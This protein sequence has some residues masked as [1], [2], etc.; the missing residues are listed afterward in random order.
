M[1]FDPSTVGA[2]PDDTQAPS[3]SAP[4]PAAPAFDPTALGAI[5]DAP[6]PQA[7][8]ATPAAPPT[9]QA[10]PFD[11]ASAGAVPD[12]D[13][14]S[15]GATLDD[16]NRDAF[17]DQA[18]QN[19]QTPI[20]QKVLNTAKGIGE[21]LWSFATDT[22]PG[23]IKGA[24]GLA[25]AP[26]MSVGQ[27]ALAAG[28]TVLSNLATLPYL[29][30]NAMQGVE[31]I[32]N[33]NFGSGV[34]AEDYGKQWDDLQSQNFT[35][36]A[37]LNQ[38]L[39]AMFGQASPENALPATAEKF[40]EQLSPLL[41]VTNAIPFAGGA[42]AKLGR[43]G[44]VA[45]GDDLAR[46]TTADLLKDGELPSASIPRRI[47][48]GMLQK[49]AGLTDA[50]ANI[51]DAVRSAPQR[52]LE[53]LGMPPEAAEKM[54]G[55]PIHLLA[56]A[57]GGAE[58][59]LPILAGEAAPSLLRQLSMIQRAAAT[60]V[61]TGE[62]TASFVQRMARGSTGFTQ[63]VM[64]ALDQ[65]GIAR[66][67]GT[68][69]DVAA[70]GV[71]G[72]LFNPLLP[73]QFLASQTPEQFGQ[74]VGQN[75]GFGAAGA[76]AAHLTGESSA[77][78]AMRNYNDVTQYAA[79][80]AKGADAD[81]QLAAYNSLPFH[82]QTVI[83]QFANTRPDV[84]LTFKPNG[85]NA[86]WVGADGVRNVQINSANGARSAIGLIAGHEFTHTL[87]SVGDN[88]ARV[89][90]A[91]MGNPETGA[92]GLLG[93]YAGGMFVPH[94][95]L[96][97][98]A[99][100]YEQALGANGAAVNSR[101]N[102]D[103]WRTM[104]EEYYADH[105]GNKLAGTNAAG[106]TGY[107]RVYRS[108]DTISKAI[109]TVLGRSGD[110]VVDY[111]DRKY[112]QGRITRF[113]GD[114]I[115]A[116]I[117][118]TPEGARTLRGIETLGL[119]AVRNNETLSKEPQEY[120]GAQERGTTWGLNELRQNPAVA[121]KFLGAS[122]DLVWAPD[123]TVTGQRTQSQ[124]RAASRAQGR[125]WFTALAGSKEAQTTPGAMRL[126]TK[127]DAKGRQ[128]AELEGK[129]L[130]EAQLGAVVKAAGYNRYQEG[131]L[132]QVNRALQAGDGNVY[133]VIYQTASKGGKY[134]TLASSNRDMVVRQIRVTK[135]YNI[136]LDSFDV[137]QFLKNYQ[138]SLEGAAARG[139]D[140]PLKNP[141]QSLHDYLANQALGYT[142]AGQPLDAANPPTAKPARVF[143][144]A[145]ADHLNE[146]FGVGTKD[147]A[148]ANPR[149]DEMSES[150][151]ERSTSTFKSFR[152]DRINSLEATADKLPVD[153]NRVKRNRSPDSGQDEPQRVGSAHGT[154]NPN[155]AVGRGGAG[156]ADQV[157]AQPADGDEPSLP[158]QRNPG[159]RAAGDSG[160]PGQ[161]PPREQSTQGWGLP[162]RAPLGPQVGTRPEGVNYSP[163]GGRRVLYSPNSA[164]EAPRGG[165]DDVRDL[166]ERYRA[167]VPG[168]LP[169]HEG[170][171]PVDQDLSRRVA[172]AYQKLKSDPADPRVR[173]AYDAFINE[174]LAQWNVAHAN[175]YKFEPWLKGGQP[176]AT[177]ADMIADLRDNRHLHFLP[178]VPEGG[179]GAFG[180]DPN[181][182]ASHPLLRPVGSWNGT[183]L[184]ANDI[185]RAVHDMFGH[186]QSGYEFGP[187]G[188]LNAFLEHRA[189]YSSLAREAMTPETMG[190]NSWVNFGAHLR[191]PDGTIPA[192]RGEEGFMRP[193]ERPYAEQKAA[194][195]PPELQREIEMKQ[196]SPNGVDEG[197]RVEGDEPSNRNNDPALHPGGGAGGGGGQGIDV[198]R[199][200][201][202]VSPQRFFN[203][204]IKSTGRVAQHPEFQEAA[205]HLLN[206]AA[207]TGKL[208]SP[209]EGRAINAYKWPTPSVEHEVYLVPPDA[210]GV[211]KGIHS[212]GSI[213]KI[214]KPGKW[215]IRGSDLGYFKS[216][217][218]QEV[219]TGGVLNTEV[220]GVMVRGAGAWPGVVTRM[221][222]I[223]GTRPTK[224]DLHNFLTTPQEQ[225]GP[226]LEWD[227][228]NNY[229]DPDSDL[230]ILDAHTGN[231]IKTAEG[232]FVPIDVYIRG[233]VGDSRVRF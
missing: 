122:N 172:D 152:L 48:S 56:G 118:S 210:P 188:E 83:A 175:G 86:A 40:Q 146:L 202:P 194:L 230:E 14:A 217:H 214:T 191:R 51:L 92:D 196:Y 72:G 13:P 22:V 222:F 125:A 158:G 150:G 183:P 50:G 44:L 193:Q 111:L 199:E 130:T 12:F 78:V 201:R 171:A 207:K 101:P 84:A 149:F 137:D 39:Q 4:A 160:Q 121:G 173:A 220:M 64:N 2:I 94:D 134:A 26:D 143:S 157:P 200:L 211:L 190:Q 33:R 208:I 206:Y 9:P 25:T 76:A 80:L 192:G 120:S 28:N 215:G 226:G 168:L 102:D 177:S 41:D 216:L 61:T 98:F 49:G 127:T 68:M 203:D 105:M 231:F 46:A 69:G 19:D 198:Q 167:A 132:R 133:H 30:S 182:D 186:A 107:S 65:T 11:P 148:G 109:D 29:A 212:D 176:Y 174:T 179:I 21:G 104:S 35:R 18:Q 229:H 219:L 31:N 165:S 74:Q 17:I 139:R 128:V 60:A 66:V 3:Q 43:A 166:A 71:K 228:F 75:V 100:R 79:R 63:T 52:G 90:G 147:N 88:R 24:Y 164:D 91:L 95:D 181:V 1:A 123:G 197:A 106:E 89:M 218:D 110:R 178:S 42:I 62:S 87:L 99:R 108:G 184:V 141:E 8:A 213:I 93:R 36:R 205:D 47:A 113:G 5:P 169:P 7:S 151:D 115:T 103:Y 82:A 6:A 23:I 97:S 81:G 58:T 170:Y 221:N 227:G 144:A 209:R 142:G 27:K 112:A 155:A 224:G 233:S 124:A 185:F 16:P 126:V 114:A 59:I 117:K 225:G 67:M 159:V 32:Y 57:A 163:D 129:F 70:S 45:A 232:Y 145:D 223:K 162:D 136:I 73:L 135:D 195:L 53:A 54:A 204:Y 161:N 131:A 140:F 85:E 96:R 10:A 15:A 180:E 119:D 37:F 116:R 156:D 187:R 38:G 20:G 138:R 55:A 153:Y 189:M 154:S 34:S 77:Q